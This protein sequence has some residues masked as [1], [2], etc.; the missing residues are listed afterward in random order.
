[1]DKGRCEIVAEAK[2]IKIVTDIF[3]DEKILLIESLPESDSLIVIWF[4]LLCLA[5][6][7]NNSGVFMLNGTIPYNDEMFATIFR[8]NVNTVRMALQTFEK[9]GMIEIINNAVTIPNWSKHQNLDQL[10]KRNEYQKNYMKEYREKQKTIAC[11]PNSK[12]NSND[13]GETNNDTNSNI[14]SNINSEP[15]VSTLD[16]NRIDKKRKDIKDIPDKSCDIDLFFEECW[17]LYPNKKGKGSIKATQKKKLFSFRDEFKRAIGRYT[18]E[19]NLQRINPQFI[20]YGS[21]FF[22]S[23]YIDYLDDQEETE[24]NLTKKIFDKEDYRTWQL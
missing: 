16:K 23:G 8:R 17:Q 13:N 4:K 9:F 2:W 21:T 15:H 12:T 20:K 11:K 6:K 19:I 24:T 22:N 1:M 5:G 3:D 10:E 14:N 18:D 7:N